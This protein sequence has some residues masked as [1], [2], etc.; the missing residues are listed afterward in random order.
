ML[1]S[2]GTG[3]RLYSDT[4]TQFIADASSGRIAELMRVS[5]YDQFRFNPAPSEL[6]SWRNSLLALSGVFRS[7]RLDDHGVLLEYQL[8]LASKRLDCLV[9]GKDSR[10]ADQAMI[11]ELKQWQ[12]CEPAP[13]DNEVATFI[14]GRLRDV[15]HPS[16]QVGQ[17][18]QYLEETHTAFYGDS[19][20]A[21][22]SCA[23]LHNYPYDPSDAIFSDKFKTLT[24]KFPIYTQPDTDMLSVHLGTTME[25]GRGAPILQRI[26]DGEYSPS[27][28][29]LDH[30]GQI[31]KGDARYILLDE[32]LV[33]YDKVLA[34]ARESL[35]DQKT[36]ILIKGGPGT[37][38][39]VIALNLMADLLLDGYNAHYATGSK[40]FTETLRKIIGTRGG[41]QFK[42][43]NSYMGVP[44][45]T[46]D[47]LIA[48]EAHRIRKTSSNRFTPTHRRSGKAQVE[49]MIDAAR[50]SVFFIDDLQVVRPDEVGSVK[51]IE[52]HAGLKGCVLQDYEL[53]AQFRCGGSDGYI[54]WVNNTLGVS[55]TANIL[56]DRA[57][58]FDFQICDSPEAVE[59]KIRAKAAEGHSARMTAGFC[60]P[61]SSPLVDG[62]L[63]HD[64]T[65]GDYE[66]PWNAKPDAG[67][68]APGI[69]KA[70]VWAH[71]PTGIDQIG[72]IYTAQGFEFDYAGVIVGHDLVYDLDKQ[73][74]IGQKEFSHDGPVKRS[75]DQFLELTKNTYR[76]LLTRGLKGCYVCFLDKSTEQFF[77]SR[78]ERSV[79]SE[80]SQV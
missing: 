52:E 31:I 54:N 34:C 56:W 80:F 45:N 37:G 8:P 63:V 16:A 1:A 4:S 17:Y 59:A 79:D 2:E 43:F 23:Y 65:I 74:W 38:K 11:V 57:E 60:W 53:E 15:L 58:Q 70:P 21:L 44:E 67:R 61:W 3:V 30:V 73:T 5:F 24:Q 20:V 77:K 42:Y 39:S 10:G 14:G 9:C 47:V 27:K 13:G 46:I 32:Q 66:R 72:C 40:A 18:Q 71:D 12:Q 49:E 41:V 19:P 64:V 48:D 36:V 78:I 35:D 55:K 25:G 6:N 33:V 68:L 50:V 75:K 22:T 7:A 76:V 28:K 62:T 26:E 51:H 29:L 69:P